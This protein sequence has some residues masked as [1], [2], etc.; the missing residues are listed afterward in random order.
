ML[1]EEFDLYGHRFRW[2]AADAFPTPS[3]A[4]PLLRL[5]APLSDSI[6]WHERPEDGRPWRGTSE[7]GF[8]YRFADV[9][10][11][12]VPPGGRFLQAFLCPHA[13][14]WA[15][16]FVLSRGVIPRLLHLRGA[17]CLHASAVA[18]NGGVVAFCGPTGSGKSTVAAA[19]ARR[20]FAFVTDDVLPL[21]ATPAAVL[22]GPGLPEARLYPPVAERLGLT[23]VVTPPAPGQTKSVW[24]PETSVASALPLARICLLEPAADA[25][26]DALLSLLANSFWLDAGATAPLAADLA[27][28]AQVVRSVPISRLSF[29]PSPAFFDRVAELVARQ[30]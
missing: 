9:A 2:F 26:I 6:V 13:P 11:F 10:E 12:L 30:L 29:D 1:P 8:A 3:D 24:R 25:P 19:M 18:A 14:A 28:F 20:G 17:T 23:D 21:R 27:L 22:A 15:V 16:H 7:S 5:A 4:I